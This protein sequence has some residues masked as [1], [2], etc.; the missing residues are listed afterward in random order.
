MASKQRRIVI[1]IIMI[2]QRYLVLILAQVL[3]S[4]LYVL[5]HLILTTQQGGSVSDPCFTGGS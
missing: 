3:F 2:A 5:I 4:T 1:T